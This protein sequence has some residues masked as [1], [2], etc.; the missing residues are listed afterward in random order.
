MKTKIFV[1][2]LLITGVFVFPTHA[3][4]ACQDMNFPNGDRICLDLNKKSSNQYE[5]RLQNSRLQNPN[6]LT[7]T[8]TL[9]NNKKVKLTRCEGNF[10][11][12]GGNGKVEI[13]ADTNEGFSMLV[14]N[15][16]FSRGEFNTTTSYDNNN[17]NN[18]Q[19]YQNYQIEVINPGSS[20]P[21][22]SEQIDAIIKVRY[23][24]SSYYYNNFNGRVDLSLE[25]YRNGRW[26]TASSSD[27]NLERSSI[28]FNSS[29][30]GEIRVNRL[31]S[32]RNKGEFRLVAKINETNASS[33]T[34]FYVNSYGYDNNRWD[35]NNNYHNSEVS[36]RV[37]YDSTWSRN[38]R[39]KEVDV[40]VRFNN[41]YRGRAYF[42]IEEY[43]NGR[44]LAASS[45]DY[46]L[47]NS[48]YYFDGYERSR[49]FSNLIRFYNQ[50]KNYRIIVKLDNGSIS[51]EEIRFS[52]SSKHE[53]NNSSS[54]NYSS[55]EYKKLKA[56]YE[57]W[58]QVIK[59]LKSDYPRL[60]NSSQWTRESEDFYTNMRE[61]VNN[62][63][64]AKFESRSRFYK[65]FGEWLNLTIK[66]RG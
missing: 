4:A 66:I 16:D 19:R 22:T 35:W 43:S 15:Y 47:Q 26:Q 55:S 28:Y 31:L 54:L 11:Y 21:S 59:T 7:C 39:S 63:R 10:E 9:P 18:S 45:R 58:P 13:E 60:R 41:Y 44:W 29:D 8:L 30:R 32:F 40:E 3:H 52:T 62:N 1:L 12:R 64:Y 27:Y 33:Y 6:D 38:T 50:D 20:N 34:S 42:E 53:H 48:N 57:L 61:A 37:S 36:L 25:E 2:S 56:V 24:G 14:A 17:N 65:A 51:R 23:N 49:N 46:D 5:I